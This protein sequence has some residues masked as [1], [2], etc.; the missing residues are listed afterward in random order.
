MS[1]VTVLTRLAKATGWILLAPILSFPYF[2]AVI[3]IAAAV[4]NSTTNYETHVE[5]IKQAAALSYYSA[6][7]LLFTAPLIGV[8]ACYLNRWSHQHFGALACWLLCA[9]LVGWFHCA[10]FLLLSDWALSLFS[11]FN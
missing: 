9:V 3:N 7:L 10:S 6:S 1:L 5:W 11:F 2:A 8:G 4:P